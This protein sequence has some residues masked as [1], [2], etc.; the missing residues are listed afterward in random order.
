MTDVPKQGQISKA[1]LHSQIL[2]ARPVQISSFSYIFREILDPPQSMIANKNVITGRNEVVAK[3]IFLHLSVILFTGGGVLSQC[4]LGYHP[5][6]QTPPGADP[7]WDQTPLGADT[8][9]P[10]EQTHPPGSRH[11]RSRHPPRETDSSIRS[12]NGR[13]ASYWNAFLLVIFLSQVFVMSEVVEDICRT[14][15]IR[16]E[17]GILFILERHLIIM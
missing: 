9:P 2:H 13:Y 6:E 11:P 12:T 3:V 16:I 5:P 1:D 8:P 15:T 14:F 4:M 10:R 17:V 7:P